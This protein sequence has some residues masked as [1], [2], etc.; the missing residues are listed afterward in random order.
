M[1]LELI[2]LVRGLGHYCGGN[3]GNRLFLDC[4]GEALHGVHHSGIQ[5]S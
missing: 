3:R 1:K 5:C 2:W 4:A